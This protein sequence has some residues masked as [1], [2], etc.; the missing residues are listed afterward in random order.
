[1]F[2]RS[3]KKDFS[4][5]D[6]FCNNCGKCGH[7]FNQCKLP[8]MSSGVIAFRIHPTTK[9]IEYLMICRKDTLGYMDFLRGKFSVYQKYYILNM[10]KQMTQSE[11]VKLKQRIANQ[12]FGIEDSELSVW[13]EN[14]TISSTLSGLTLSKT[15]GETKSEIE[16]ED[17]SDLTSSNKSSISVKDKIRWLINGVENCGETYNLLSLI[18]ETEMGG[19]EQWKEPEWGFPKGRR[20]SQES[21]YDC[22]I[23]EFSEETGIPTSKLQNIRNIFPF[24]ELFTGSNYKSYR[25]K[26]FLMYIDYNESIEFKSSFQ[27]NEV[28]QISWKTIEECID[29]IRP[30][31]L[32]K[33]KM[34]QNVDYCLKNTLL[35]Y[36]NGVNI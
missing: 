9:Q 20:N 30:Y 18:Q 25:H 19:T 3:N 31:N 22:A 27:R 16:S 17:M 6:I 24:E 1:M 29:T 8:I 14:K 34:I 23:R 32:E 28:S 36:S 11:K 2:H 15:F 21:D 7:I 35:F 5:I 12:K 26:Y 4:F 13:S 10:I 33:K